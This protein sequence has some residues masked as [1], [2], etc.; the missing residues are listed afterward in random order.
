MSFRPSIKL[1]LVLLALS[2]VF[3]RLGLWQ[4]DRKAEKILLFDSFQNAP[5]KPIGQALSGTAPFVRVEAEGRYDPVRH[6]LYDNRIFKGRAGVHVL[7]PFTLSDGSEILINRGWLPL[8]PDRRSLPEFDTNPAQQRISGMLTRPVTGGQRVGGADELVTDQW[9][10]LMTY[11]DLDSIGA[12]TEKSLEPW[13][14]LLDAADPSGFEDRQWRAAVMEPKVHGAY[15]LQWFSLAAAAM[16]I[17]I[18]LG[19][20]RARQTNGTEL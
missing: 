8:A 5:V 20:R 10:Q 16:V 9:P 15:A 13:V 19:V 17:W 12:A 18:V 2:V 14:L 7:T 4:W 1:T 11:L 3:F 6:T